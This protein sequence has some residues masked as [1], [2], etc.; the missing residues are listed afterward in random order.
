MS[1]EIS[2]KP[3]KE[4]IAVVGGGMTGIA[5]ALGLAQSGRFAVTLLEKQD[6]IGGLSGYFQ[7]Q[8]VIWD[9][10]YHVMLSTDTVMLDFIQELRSCA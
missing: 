9:R 8:D 1:D 5:A 6:R 4:T 7:W 2:T 3:P 10:F